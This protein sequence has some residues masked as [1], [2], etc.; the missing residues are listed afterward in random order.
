MT[1]T[2]DI[3]SAR[4]QLEREKRK[5][6]H[7]LDELGASEAGDLRSD[8]DFGDSFSD[9]AATTAERTERLGLVVSVKGMLDDVER[10]LKRIDNGT[11][12]ICINCGNQI[13]AARLEF[14][15]ESAY[16]VGCKTRNHH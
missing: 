2:I 4:D 6:I 12:G 14:R 8:V 7:Q 16:C 13:S 11:Y 5:L 15:P 10:A 1:M 9:A 3:Q